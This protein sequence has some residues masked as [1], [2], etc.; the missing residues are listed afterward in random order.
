MAFGRVDFVLSLVEDANGNNPFANEK[1]TGAFADVDGDGD[2]DLFKKTLWINDGTGHFTSGHV[3][4]GPNLDTLPGTPGNG[5]GAGDPEW[6][7]CTK[8]A[9]VDNDGDVDLLLATEVWL[10]DGTGTFTR[11]SWTW[12]SSAWSCVDGNGDSINCV[13]EIATMAVGDV[14]SDGIVDLFLAFGWR[15]S[16][17]DEDWKGVEVQLGD[18]TGSFNRAWHSSQQLG[19]FGSAL[20]DFTGDGVLD[21]FTMGKKQILWIGLGNGSFTAIPE[22]GG[23]SGKTTEPGGDMAAGASN[24]LWFD[25]DG[26]GDMDLYLPAWYADSMWIND[27]TGQFSGAAADDMPSSFLGEIQTSYATAGD[28]DGDGDTDIILDMW[29]APNVWKAFGRNEDAWSTSPGGGFTAPLFGSKAVALGDIDGDGDLDIFIGNGRVTMGYNAMGVQKDDKVLDELWVNDGNGLF[30]LSSAFTKS[31]DH[32]D[33]AGASWGDANGD[34]H[35]DLFL[36]PSMELWMNNGDLT[37]TLATGPGAPGSNSG[38]WGD[39]DGDG[40]LDLCCPLMLNDGNGAFTASQAGPTN[41]ASWGDADGDGDLDLCCPLMLN[42]GDGGFAAAVSLQEADIPNVDSFIAQWVDVDNDG[43]LDIPGWVNDGTGTFTAATVLAATGTDCTADDACDHSD[44]ILRAYFSWDTGRFGDPNAI[45]DQIDPREY[46]WYALGDINHDGFVDIY[47]FDCRQSNHVYLN[48]GAGL[49]I[50]DAEN[51]LIGSSSDTMGAAF[52]DL[53]GDGSLDMVIADMGSAAPASNKM[54]LSGVCGNDGVRLPFG[55]C[56]VCSPFA[57]TVGGVRCSECPEHQARN[58]NGECSYCPPG[59]ER[60]LGATECTSCPLGYQWAEGAAC[61]KCPPG[62]YAAALGTV[63]CVACPA[64]SATPGDGATSAD[65][66]GCVEGYFLD[67]AGGTVACQQCRNVLEFSTSIELGANSADSCSCIIG[68]Y[69]DVVNGTKVCVECD[70]TVM[71]C[72]IP[73]ITVANMPIM[74]GG[75]RLSNT[76]TMVYECFNPAACKGSSGLLNATGQRRRLLGNGGGDV[77]TA[78]D[79]LCAAGHTGFLCATCIDDWCAA[80]P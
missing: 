7:G 56:G 3:D 36:R 29:G 61:T 32:L 66:C 38:S 60:V 46:D 51:T 25:A 74:A 21:L 27:G 47:L 78:G 71:D 72:T 5:G 12:D 63:A 79:S 23:P 64:F 2:L 4:G 50:L 16:A 77:S 18:G 44:R 35:L 19:A 31:D 39:A 11:G 17:G 45:S 49:F 68:Y 26:D 37:F 67:D 57:I 40:D 30:T 48:N 1:T 42:D 41:G 58:A 53:N 52:G 43:D 34:G 15:R 13:D 14:N 65:D 10:N 24:F 59:S 33:T 62:S 55:A 73:G 70:L 6:G 8:F 76:T 28:L 69:L 20:V 80:Q 9:D 54:W 22:D 75:W